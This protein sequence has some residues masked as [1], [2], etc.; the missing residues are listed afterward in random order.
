MDDQELIEVLR[1]LEPGKAPASMDGRVLDRA[2]GSAQSLARHGRRQSVAHLLASAAAVL[3]L[4]GLVLLAPEEERSVTGQGSDPLAAATTDSQGQ[5]P[6]AEATT[7]S[8]AP[9]SEDA[10]YMKARI[11]ELKLSRLKHMAALSS[12]S[13]RYRA[14]LYGLERK[15]KTMDSRF[16]PPLL[17]EPPDLEP[18]RAD[19][20]EQDKNTPDPSPEMKDKGVNHDEESSRP[21]SPSF[22]HDLPARRRPGKTA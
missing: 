15:L 18:K 8:R 22:L 3:L 20:A 1:K 7:E 4:A 9:D 5:D 6:L 17:T 10:L 21:V 11:L 2:E 12:R 14:D 19:K 16:R 13:S